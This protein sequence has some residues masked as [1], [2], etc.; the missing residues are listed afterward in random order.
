MGKAKI[1][2]PEYGTFTDERDGR[3]YRTVKMPDGKIWMAQ[4]LNYKPESGNY[5][6]YKKDESM[7]EKY[8][9]LYDWDTA[10]VVSP[11][12][13]H[14]P[15][16]EEWNDLVSAVG[17]EEVAGKKLKSKNG[18]NNKD[19]GSNGNG[20]DDFGFSALPGGDRDYYDGSFYG[21]GA[22]GYWWTAAEHS[23]GFAYHVC[24]H[25]CCDYSDLDDDYDYDD[26]YVDHN[27]VYVSNGSK[28]VGH[29]VRCVKDDVR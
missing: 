28:R 17:G 9:R 27:K 1:A 22:G 8:G 7:G 21:A 11:V 5:W 3:T 19:D 29:S 2:E 13:W 23:N 15:S 18:W 6:F 10:M 16:L 4:N 12:G 26:V 25:S 14:L 20:T 24:M